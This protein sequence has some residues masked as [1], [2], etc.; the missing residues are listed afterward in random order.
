MRYVRTFQTLITPPYYSLLHSHSLFFFW[1]RDRGVG[2]EHW[3]RQC[4]HIEKI[5]Y[6]KQTGFTSLL[7]FILL[8]F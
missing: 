6:S 2:G 3:S 5:R 8:L 7:L 4:L 1:W